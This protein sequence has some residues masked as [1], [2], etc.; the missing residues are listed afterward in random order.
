MPENPSLPSNGSPPCHE[1]NPV[2]ARPSPTGFLDPRD[3]APCPTP[4]SSPARA[5][6]PP[7]PSNSQGSHNAHR[8]GTDQWPRT[9][10]NLSPH[11]SHIPAS[12]I[13]LSR[14]APPD[15]PGDS[16]SP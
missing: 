8:R 5:G 11:D 3:L 1:T 4:A 15:N 6:P 2:P 10:D 14:P 12:S 13:L 9:R 16:Q 7:T